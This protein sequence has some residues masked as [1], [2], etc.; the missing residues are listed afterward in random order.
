[1]KLSPFDGAL[2]D[3]SP[4]K[5][6]SGSSSKDRIPELALE[7]SLIPR[8]QEEQPKDDSNKYSTDDCS[9]VAVGSAAA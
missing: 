7:P 3:K 5:R 4:K 6:V 8:P 2:A 1:M 9:G